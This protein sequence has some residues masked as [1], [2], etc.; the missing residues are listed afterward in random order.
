MDQSR[1][2]PDYLTPD[3]DFSLSSFFKTQGITQGYLDGA[4]NDWWNML[5]GNGYIQS[6]DVS[7]RG[8][9]ENITYFISGGYTGQEG[10]VE[11]D[12]YERY[13]VRLNLGTNITDWLNVGV[14]SFVT[15]SDYSGVSPNVSEA[16][17]LQP[18]AP[19]FE[20]D[21]EYVL[22][23]ENGLNPFLEMQIDDA[24]KRLN[25]FGNFHTDI[26]LPFLEGFNYRINY[27]HNYRTINQAN[28]NP[29]GANY[30]GLGI[31]DSDTYYDWTF[32]NIISY[33]KE[34]N[35][36]HRIDVTLLHGV[37]KRQFQSDSATAQNFTNMV[38]G[39]NKLE[40]G[41][42]TLFSVNSGAEEEASLYMMGRL[43]YS[44]KDKYL[45]TG[46]VRRDGFSGF[47][48]EN[49]FGIFPS[50]ALGWVATEESFL[51]N[52]SGWLDYLKLRASYGTTARRGVKRYQTLAQVAMEPSRVFGDGGNTAIG[53]WISSMANNNLG[54]ETTTGLNLGV[55][56]EIVNSRI[57][58]NFE[59][60]NNNTSDIL[61]NIQIPNITG[62]SSIA[63]NIGEVHNY[64]IE[65]SLTGQVINTGNF[66]W[67]T[68][69]NFSRNRNRIESILGV[70]NDGDGQEDDIITNN[71]FIGEPQNV[72]YDYK[73]TGM[74]QLADEEAEVIPNGFFPGTYQIADTD[75]DGEYS[76]LDRQIIGYRDPAYRFS[77]NNKLNYKN[78]S[79]NVFINSIQGG[80][81]YYYGDGSPYADGLHYKQD[82]LSYSNVPGWDYWMPENP[83]AKY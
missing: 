69:V 12:T 73:I 43:F 10:F 34:L 3:P 2:A 36:N 61:Y 39:Y 22:E 65:L 20:E 46:T 70:D 56:F 25:L 74:W 41:D 54:W 9:S 32:D 16:F 51:T 62:F 67:Q 8:Q 82:Q 37:E 47:G 24:D 77:I 60:Y 68:T 27:A 49:K 81:N 28:F 1:L 6:H 29:W 71:L 57:Y 55:D 21:G 53:Q 38:L 11:N 4:D 44:F 78:F 63:T 59:Y 42:P 58:G 30:T 19:I 13:N 14:E 7:I 66:R 52:T 26:K 64:G 35:Q 76:P 15:S 33:Q 23:P 31:K 75:G 50:L 48:T 45:I 80:S 83:N 17:H 18:Y 5:T 40:A 79:L 72:I